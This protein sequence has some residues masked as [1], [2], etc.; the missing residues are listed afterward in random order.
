MDA[1]KGA[2]RH[3]RW[4]S[5]TRGDPLVQAHWGTAERRAPVRWTHVPLTTRRPRK[6]PQQPRRQTQD[7]FAHKTELRP[8]R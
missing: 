8:K 7:A 1:Q 6:L 5:E 3:G 2:G 4:W